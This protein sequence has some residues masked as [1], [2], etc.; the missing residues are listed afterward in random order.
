MSVSVSVYDGEVEGPSSDTPPP[1]S[2]GMRFTISL[3]PARTLCS[4]TNPVV[5]STMIKSVSWL[6]L[7]RFFMDT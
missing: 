3:A 5:S 1:R 7:L 4:T 6:T 2:T